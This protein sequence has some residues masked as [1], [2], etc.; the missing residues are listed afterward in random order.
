MTTFD[1][2][3][4]QVGDE[5]LVNGDKSSIDLSRRILF[6]GNRGFYYQFAAG[7]QEGSMD[8]SMMESHDW[9]IRHVRRDG[10]TIFNNPAPKVCG[11]CGKPLEAAS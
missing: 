6:I 7:T 10:K 1:P 8:F 5:I 2:K 4:L 3:T 11:C 9:R